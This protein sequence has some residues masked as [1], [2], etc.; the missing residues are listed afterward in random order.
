MLEAV[1]TPIRA[2]ALKSTYTYS[3]PS[4]LKPK[5]FHSVD[6]RKTP[7]TCR[8]KIKRADSARRSNFFKNVARGGSTRSEKQRQHKRSC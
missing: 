6:S 1:A 3:L 7:V 5:L 2:K 8:E 4:H